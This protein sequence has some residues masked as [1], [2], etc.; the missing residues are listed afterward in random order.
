VAA[1]EGELAGLVSIVTGGGGRLGGEMARALARDGARVVVADIDGGRADTR[2]ASIADAGGEC[3]AVQVDIGDEASVD[4]AFDAIAE[5][6]GGVDVLVNNA[7]P[8][9]LV[10][11]DA[12]L[13]E[14]DLDTW[15]AMLR[16]IL[17]GTMLCSR[18]AIPMLSSRGG[19]SIINI[20]S[21][22]AH[23]GDPELTAYPVAKAGLLGITRAI[24]TQ[25]GSVGV[26]CNTIT[27]GT[28]LPGT[29]PEAWRR[30][31]VAHQLV[32]RDGRPADAANAVAF[33][34]SPAASF[35]T[36]ADLAVDGGLLAHLPSYA[37]A[38]TRLGR[39]RGEHDEGS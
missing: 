37:D 9:A 39:L 13:A 8:T 2:A 30:S 19:G 28:Y 25:Y 32:P 5:R 20:A 34:A 36:G 38:G 14:I 24:A 35:I 26:R 15:D 23:A 29:A 27:L 1:T 3:M 33:L 31:K 10:A 22:H 12:P 6:F 21:I 11:H 17:R 16:G 4:A 18:R 7:A